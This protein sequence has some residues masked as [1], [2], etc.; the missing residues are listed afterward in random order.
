MSAVC[1]KQAQRLM[2]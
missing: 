1:I 2:Q